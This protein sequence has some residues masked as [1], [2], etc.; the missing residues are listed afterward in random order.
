[1]TPS[2]KAQNGKVAWSTEKEGSLNIQYIF[3][4]TLIRNGSLHASDYRHCASDNAVTRHFD[5]TESLFKIPHRKD[6]YIMSSIAVHDREIDN[7]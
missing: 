5:Q 3:I 1:M 6:H 4:K 2:Q 7:T